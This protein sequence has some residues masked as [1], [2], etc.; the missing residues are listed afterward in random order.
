MAE[1]SA[2]CALLFQ[3]LNTEQGVEN[4][5]FYTEDD[6]LDD[7]KTF[8]ASDAVFPEEAEL[9]FQEREKVTL[10]G[11]EYVREVCTANLKGHT[12]TYRFF[13]RK[14]DDN[15]MCIIEADEPDNS[16]TDAYYTD[17]FS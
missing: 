9:V 2:R 12:P 10:G 16:L 6:Y 13:V 8:F 7:F 14:L 15:L 1:M 3:F 11:K 4:G 17:L 5:A